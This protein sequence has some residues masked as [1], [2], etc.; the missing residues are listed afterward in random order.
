MLE[1]YEKAALNDIT[2]IK[3]FIYNHPKAIDEPCPVDNSLHLMPSFES[4]T[5]RIIG[6]A[7]G[8]LLT[9]LVVPPLTIVALGAQAVDSA[10]VV[11]NVYKIEKRSRLHW[12]M[13]DYAAEMGAVDVAIF[14]ILNGANTENG[15]FLNLAKHNGH[16]KFVI[17]CQEAM[18]TYAENKAKLLKLQND[19][20]ELKIAKEVPQHNSNLIMLKNICAQAKIKQLTTDY[21]DLCQYSQEGSLS[22]KYAFLEEKSYEEIHEHLEMLHA[23]ICKMNTDLNFVFSMCSNQP[24]E[25]KEYATKKYPKL[26]QKYVS[27]IADYNDFTDMHHA[28]YFG[29]VSEDFPEKPSETEAQSVSG[30]P[31]AFFSTKPDKF[32][33]DYFYTENDVE[34]LLSLSIADHWPNVSI[35]G[36]ATIHELDKVTSI[37]DI[38]GLF[39]SQS[40]DYPTQTTLLLPI[41]IGEH[42]VGLHLKLENAQ[43]TYAI[44]FNSSTKYDDKSVKAKIQ[45]ELAKT[46]RLAPT[47]KFKEPQQE[48]KQSDGTSCGP[49]LVENMLSSLTA[50]AVPDDVALL[51]QR[52][53]DLIEKKDPTYFKIFCK[54]DSSSVHSVSAQM[55]GPR[56]PK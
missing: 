36:A 7:G 26:Y 8:A 20:N 50:A 47:F 48:A 1:K 30:T 25:V 33:K 34:K 13:L 14:L 2:Y 5:A 39:F 51:R 55:Q 16:H 17:S 37:S 35:L 45:A 4:A 28:T 19:I 56:F 24:D 11:Y 44:Y 6:M 43:I 32:N 29:G 3:N 42:W 27:M 10:R 18:K 38:L 9:S 54:Q 23:E 12:T 46:N 41:S 52:H 31:S 49:F 21:E 22:S 53:W 40:Q 15:Y